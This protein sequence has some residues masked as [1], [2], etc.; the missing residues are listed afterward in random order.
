[1]PIMII[2]RCERDNWEDMAD[3][4]QKLEVFEKEGLCE[5]TSGGNLT[6]TQSSRE[7]LHD[8]RTGT[9]CRCPCRPEMA[10]L[11]REYTSQY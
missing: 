10:A 3:K 11:L 8:H 2:K 5:Q 6:G 7:K 4:E 1:M 9:P